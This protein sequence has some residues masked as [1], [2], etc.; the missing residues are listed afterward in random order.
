MRIICT[1]TL[2]TGGAGEKRR[3]YSPG[4]P[5]DL[6]DEEAQDLIK[7]SLATLADATEADVSDTGVQEERAEKIAEAALSLDGDD[8]SLWLQDGRPTV[9]AVSAA[10][11]DSVSSEERDEA[12]AALEA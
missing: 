8:E 4:T 10:F 12:W 1:A 11:G 7:R 5:V 2:E 9:A 6:P 3:V